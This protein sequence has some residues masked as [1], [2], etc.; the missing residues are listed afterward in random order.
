[1]HSRFLSS[2]LAHQVKA[3]HAK[4]NMYCLTIT[5][6]YS[7]KQPTKIRS[8]SC[9]PFDVKGL[10]RALA[11]LFIENSQHGPLYGL[12]SKTRTCSTS[13]KLCAAVLVESTTLSLGLR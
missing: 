13:H 2:I 5:I 8:M 7:C 12:C 10:L 11:F 1:M 9:P 4:Q 6:T 3:T